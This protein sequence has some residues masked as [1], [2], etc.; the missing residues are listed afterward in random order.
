MDV[1]FVL[2]ASGATVV[3]EVPC[4]VDASTAKGVACRAL[5][6]LP[7]SVDVRIHTDGGGDVPPA[8]H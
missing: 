3:V 8:G 6:V 7:S 2:E 4:D 5:A 1:T